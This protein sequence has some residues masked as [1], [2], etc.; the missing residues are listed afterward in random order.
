MS[1]RD[2][3]RTL[4]AVIFDMD[5]VLINSVPAVTVALEEAFGEYGFALSDLDV[6]HR[7][8]SVKM[9]LAEVARVRGI[10]IDHDTFA[11]K[12]VEHILR[13]LESEVPDPELLRLLGALDEEGVRLAVASS[14]TR[15][16]VVGK[17]RILGI[18]H[19]F[20]AVVTAEDVPRH[21]PAPDVYLRAMSMLSVDPDR[22]AVVEDTR[23]GIDSARAAG[24]WSVGFGKYTS[25]SEVEL[26]ADL[27]VS[28]W[29]KLAIPQ[30]EGL[31][32]SPPT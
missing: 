26:G 23:P 30:L 20:D 13:Q 31:I 25:D 8:H 5:G 3:R 12:L 11:Q 21:K 32:K 17:L 10:H 9:M 19:Y 2:A 24:A 27:Y 18:G 6:D 15:A 29:E 16:S 7:A 4:Q 14:S 1:H 22:T 28:G